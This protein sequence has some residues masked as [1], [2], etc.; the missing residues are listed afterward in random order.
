MKLNIFDFSDHRNFLI[1]SFAVQKERL[2]MWSYEAW[3]Q[4]LGLGDNSSLLKIV[5]GQRKVGPKIAGKLIEYFEFND[6][7]RAYFERLIALSKN[8]EK[9]DHLI[10]IMKE[11]RDLHPKKQFQLLDERKFSVIAQWWHLVIRQMTKLTRFQAKPNWISCKLRFHVP[12]G[13]IK[14]AIE[15]L[16][17][18]E[19]LKVDEKSKKLESPL[20]RIKTT[21]DL[22]LEAIKQYHEETLNLALRAVRFPI[23]QR[24][25]RSLTFNMR[26][27]DI[28]DAKSFIRNFI[29]Q[30]SDR[31]ETETHDDVFQLQ[32]QL[33]PVTLVFK[34]AV[35]KKGDQT[36]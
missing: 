11:L 23:D 29:E 21:D 18:I 20:P 27:N 14:R 8:R 2:P 22:S 28:P 36:W 24:E 31:F 34:K 9:S 5:H 26:Y 32:I 4:K 19:L 3:A 13:K 25:F 35:L 15:T 33:Y 16:K 12:P 7:E 30:F 10:R 1:S 17:K 6:R